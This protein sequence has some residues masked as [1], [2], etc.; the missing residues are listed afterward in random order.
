MGEGQTNTAAMG[1]LL[2]FRSPLRRWGGE[3]L[4]ARV[5]WRRASEPGVHSQG[6]LGAKR[7]T[8][9]FEGGGGGGE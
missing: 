1:V 8:K 6:A 3:A 7:R 2:A 9:I 5:P 4:W